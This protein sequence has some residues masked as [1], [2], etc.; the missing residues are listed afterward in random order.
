MSTP[1]GTMHDRARTNPY[2]AALQQY[3]R[4]AAYLDLPPMIHALLRAP[5]REQHVNFPVRMDDGDLRMFTGFRVHHN[6]VLGPPQGGI[7]YAPDVTL[8]EAR[9]LALWVTWSC[10]LLNLPFGGAT[11]GVIC[12]PRGMTQ[13]EL[14]RLTQRYTAEIGLFGARRDIP[15]PDMGT[16]VQTMAWITNTV[17]MAGNFRPGNPASADHLLLSANQMR[18]DVVGR[19]VVLCMDEALRRMGHCE[20]ERIRVAVQGFG[21]VG[22]WA[23]KIAHA[24]GYRVVAVSSSTGGCA[25]PDG[26]DINGVLAHTTRG[27]QLN[28]CRFANPITNR[29]LLALDV[30]VLLPCAR[31]SQ[32]TRSNAAHVGAFLVVEGASGPTTP[33][34]DA[35]LA[36]RD[37][38]VIPDILAN[39]GGVIVSYFEQVQAA[40]GFRWPTG[41]VDRQQRRVLV[42]ALDEV[43]RTAAEYG[44][45]LRTAAQI[46]AIQRVAAAVEQQEQWL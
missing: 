30:D 23:A 15:A 2:A 27:G 22:S 17:R 24:M 35:I 29:E 28:R 14:E 40:Q 8:A 46:V 45:D 6:T 5:H 1:T 41:E 12:D 10:A 36:A 31:E 13:G 7:R 26:L 38:R 32:I 43:M 33:G 44:C 19:G 18:P 3:D 42:R 16:N 34:A 9:A 4:A 20:P 21:S 11:G 39:A 37:V 25:D